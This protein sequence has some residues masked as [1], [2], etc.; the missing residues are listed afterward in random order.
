MNVTLSLPLQSSWTNSTV[1]FHAFSK[2]QS[3]WFKGPSLW[4]DSDNKTIYSW[5]GDESY[6]NRSEIN[7]KHL[8]ALTTDGNGGGTWDIQR[9]ANP[10]LFNEF[11][12]TKDAPNA[13]CHG[14]AFYL[15]G[16]ADSVSDIRVPQGEF[17]ALSGLLTYDMKTFTWANES[18]DQLGYVPY[19]GTAT[20]VSNYGSE[21]VLVFLGGSRADGASSLNLDDFNLITL[22]SIWLYD[23][24]T[25]NWLYQAT[26]GDIPSGRRNHCSVGIPGPN[27]TFEMCVTSLI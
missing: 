21:G 12:R 4:R 27:G 19:R 23:P 22:S 20:C 17:I 24:A 3:P 2:G 26:T 5:G 9:P 10:D 8:W 14:T 25:K 1:Q 18:S 13:V 7:N 11:Y 6:D 16:F 15:G